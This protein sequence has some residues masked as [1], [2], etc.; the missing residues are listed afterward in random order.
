MKTTVKNGTSMVSLILMALAIVVVTGFTGQKSFNT[1]KSGSSMTV[2][3]TSSLH[4][5]TVQVN[6]F[7]C[8]MTATADLTTMKIEMV[9]FRGKAT[10]I[11]SDNSTMDKKIQEALKSDKHPEIRYTVRSARNIVLKDKK[12]SGLITGDLQIAGKTKTEATQFTGS[13]IGENKLQITG[14][15]KI[16]MTEF[17][18]SPPTAMLGALKT[19]DEVTVQFTLVLNV[20]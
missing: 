5:W 18:I 15:K 14:S 17:G 8:D 19:G 3:G 1:Q 6:D 13:L 9:T 12:F 20:K 4:D 7:N 11:K 2:S 16:K 10:S